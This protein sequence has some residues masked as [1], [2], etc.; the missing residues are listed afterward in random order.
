MPDVDH[1]RTLDYGLADGGEREWGGSADGRLE[2]GV[3]WSG[4]AHAVQSLMPD[5]RVGLPSQ[6]WIAELAENVVRLLSPLL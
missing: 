4:D 1:P 5:S 3:E 2:E 6:S